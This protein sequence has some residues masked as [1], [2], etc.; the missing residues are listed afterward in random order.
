MQLMY[1]KKKNDLEKDKLK[2]CEKIQLIIKK[3]HNIDN[4]IKYLFFKKLKSLFTKQ[5]IK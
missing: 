5:L 1:L 2:F 4:N 3:I